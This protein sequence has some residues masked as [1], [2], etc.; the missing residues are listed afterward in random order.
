MD[1]VEKR[2]AIGLVYWVTLPVS[3]GKPSRN[4]AQ[5]LDG[6]PELVAAPP[7]SAVSV[8]SKPKVPRAVPKVPPCGWK[9]LSAYLSYSKPARILCAPL[10]LVTLMSLVYWLSRNW[11]GLPVLVL[12]MLATPDTWK[13][14]IP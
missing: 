8:P 14:G 5:E 11:K 7:L 10:I 2:R 1:Q 6:L 9:W 13:P 3:E 4:C 12:P